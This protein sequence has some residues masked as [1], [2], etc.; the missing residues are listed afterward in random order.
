MRSLPWDICPIITDC[1]DNILD[2]KFREDPLSVHP[3]FASQRR[4]VCH[5][6]VRQNAR[7]LRPNRLPCLSLLMPLHFIPPRRRKLDAEAEGQ[8]HTLH[9]AT[10]NDR[11]IARMVG[12]HRTTIR[13][14]RVTRGLPSHCPWF[15]HPLGRPASPEEISVFIKLYDVGQNDAEIGRFLGRSRCTVREWRVKRGWPAHRQEPKGGSVYLRQALSMDAP[16][17]ED[18]RQLHDIV[19]DDTWSNWLEEMGATVW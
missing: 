1:N 15:A 3:A 4:R 6:Q 5:R 7:P 16:L 12:R 2:Q 13:S 17:F 19:R 14:W 8:R 10:M 18:D 9:E 11:A